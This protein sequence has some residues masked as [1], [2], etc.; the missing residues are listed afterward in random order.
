MYNKHL[1]GRLG[2]R[3]A[4]NFLKDNDYI[5]L[6]R[7]FRCRQGEI[8]IIATDTKNR[9]LVF[10]EVKTRTNLSYGEAAEAVNR[11]KRQHIYRCVEY[12]IYVN[13]TKKLPIRIDVIEIYL[14][15]GRVKINHIKQAF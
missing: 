9:E 14:E 15:N 5:I 2:E 13:K 3:L 1:I 6:E 4:C 10:I 8:D 11:L 7:N 12:Y